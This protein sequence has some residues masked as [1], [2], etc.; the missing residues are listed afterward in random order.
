LFSADS[1]AKHSFVQRCRTALPKH[2]N[3]LAENARTSSA[4]RFMDS[5]KCKPISTAIGP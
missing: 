4:Y 3:A 1:D 5:N 2:A